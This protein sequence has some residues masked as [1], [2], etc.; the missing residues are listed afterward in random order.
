M[1]AVESR[2]EGSP[3]IPEQT[4]ERPFRHSR[5]GRYPRRRGALYAFV[6]HKTE[7]HLY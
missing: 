1:H 4:V 5:A 6:G 7:G 2:Q 3:L